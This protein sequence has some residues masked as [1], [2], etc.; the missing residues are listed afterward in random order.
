MSKRLVSFDDQATGT[1]LPAP[2]EAA[3]NATYA[4]GGRVITR[5]GAVAIGDSMTAWGS[6]VDDPGRYGHVYWSLLGIASGG[7]LR[8]DGFFATAGFTTAQIKDTHLPSVLAMNPKP[9]ACFVMCGTNDIVGG[10]R[11]TAQN[12]ADYLSICNQLVAAGICPVILTIAPHA[13]PNRSVW[14]TAWNAWLRDLASRNGFPILDFNDILVDPVT[15]GF[16]PGMVDPTDQ[17]KVHPGKEGHALIATVGATDAVFMARFPDGRPYLT[18]GINDSANMLDPYGL[19]LTDSNSDGLP[20]GWT[21]ALLSGTTASIVD[22]GKVRGKWLR[23]TKTAGATGNSYVYRNISPGTPITGVAGAAATDVFTKTAHGLVDSDKV[24]FTTAVGGVNAG[25]VYFV[26]DAS[27]NTFKVA[28]T[29]GGAA[30]DVTADGTAVLAKPTLWEPG[31]NVRLAARVRTSSAGAQ[32]VLQ[33]VCQGSTNPT[34]K[35]YS[36]MY[37]S[38]Q[39]VIDGVAQSS[40]RVPVGTH[41]LQVQVMLNGTASEDTNYDTGQVTISNLTRLAIPVS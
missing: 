9:G 26:R 28:A 16:K 2:V 39:A 7:K 13:D 15:G 11:P 23:L 14:I 37:N 35:T 32:P 31:E 21:G 1:G 33:V 25:V 6:P 22:D 24:V 30:V 27:A 40:G 17:S 10:G 4:P 38:I 19:F 3:L 18:R 29:L 12:R 41:T 5:A 34:N 36:P 8:F 20:D